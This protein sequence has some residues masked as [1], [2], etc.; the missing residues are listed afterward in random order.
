MEWATIIS[1]V[2]GIISIAFGVIGVRMAMQ[3]KRSRADFQ[4]FIRAQNWFLYE[5]TSLANAHTQL[6]LK[7]YISKHEALDPEV[8]RLL[9]MADAF[10]QDALRDVIRQMQLS[11]P[12]FDA[13]T[14]SRWIR[15]GRVP[16]GH[17]KIFGNL[18]PAHQP[19][20]DATLMGTPTPE[21]APPSEPVEA[22]Q[23][24]GSAARDQF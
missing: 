19:I 22:S 18:T 4:G 9:S 6:G 16:K 7:E 5:K 15:E 10:G 11:E 14:V 21:I 8:I 17:S 20:Q 1:V 12:R 24:R 13:E 3:E 23:G 2:F